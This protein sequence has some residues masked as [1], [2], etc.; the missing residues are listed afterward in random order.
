MRPTVEGRPLFCVGLAAEARLLEGL[1]GRVVASYGDPG[2]IEASA[3][4]MEGPP[5]CVISFGLCGGLDP[6]LRA[7]DLVL[8]LEVMTAEGA[9]SP[10]ADV[11]ER[12]ALLLPDAR[13]GPMAG[14]DAPLLT[15]V[16]KQ[17]ARAATGAAACDME[18]AA[19]AR[20]AIRLGAPFAAVRAVSDGV[21]DDLPPLALVAL[22]QSGRLRPGVIAAGLLRR[23]G[24][25]AGLVGAGIRTAAAFRALRRARGALEAL[26]PPQG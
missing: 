26:A 8:S 17:A 15:A 21:D 2:A 5:A 12:L 20:L 4:G 22:D 1:P 25:I 18:S 9:L 13:K 14:V 3:V 10:R 19:A 11:F 23:P 6:A 7:G 24:A 16:A